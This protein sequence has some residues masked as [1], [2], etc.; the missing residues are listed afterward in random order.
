MYSDG[1]Q[2]GS[3]L[4]F[5]NAGKPR[6]IDPALEAR[7][8]AQAGQ[9][10]P[11]QAGPARL[12]VHWWGL[13]V[14][15]PAP[16]RAGATADARFASAQMIEHYSRFWR[17]ALLAWGASSVQ[18]GPTLNNPTFKTSGRLAVE[19]PASAGLA[20]ARPLPWPKD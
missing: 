1:V 20:R 15:T 11:E 5:Y 12:A 18:I 7:R 19:A 16:A 17:E 9:H 4:V 3:G 8:P 14:D 10:L 6:D 2:N 13:L